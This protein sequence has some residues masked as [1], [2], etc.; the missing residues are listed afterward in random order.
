MSLFRQ[1]AIHRYGDDWLARWTGLHPSLRPRW[2]SLPS[3]AAIFYAIALS[4]SSHTDPSAPLR[5]VH[6]L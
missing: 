4:L 1:K 2:L 6:L 5:Q 3:K